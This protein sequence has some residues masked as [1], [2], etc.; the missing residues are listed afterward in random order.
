MIIH[1][2]KNFLKGKN[3]FLSKIGKEI[4]MVKKGFTI[5]EMMIVV[6]IIAILTGISIPNLLRARLAANEN[7]AISNL[8]TISVAAQT[9][10]SVGNA[11]TPLPTTLNQLYAGGYVTDDS[12]A[13]NTPPC[14]KNGYQYNMGGSGQTTD[15]FVYAV[16]HVPNVTGVRSFCSGSDGVTRVDLS[17]ATPASQTACSNLSSL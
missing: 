1:L 4:Y 17:G 10:W 13:C 16:P 2:F 15:F 5:I 14:L 3:Y 12:L 6:A 8:Q 9:F 7:N 11:A